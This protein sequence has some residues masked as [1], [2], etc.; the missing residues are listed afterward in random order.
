MP[1]NRPFVYAQRWRCSPSVSRSGLYLIRSIPEGR[2][3]LP[4]RHRIQPYGP[5]CLQLSWLNLS[6][7]AA[8]PRCL[9][10]YHQAIARSAHYA[11]AYANLAA[12][13]EALGKVKEAQTAY[14]Q[15]WQRDASLEFV[16][17]KMEALRQQNK[18]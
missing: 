4:A 15:A 5:P 1:C 8:L 2:C 17:Q 11:L 3:G 6:P 18:R 13:H 9:T 16:R 14:H 7:A 12:S 10:A